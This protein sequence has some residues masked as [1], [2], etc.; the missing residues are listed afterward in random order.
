MNNPLVVTGYKDDLLEIILKETNNHKFSRPAQKELTRLTI[1]NR[2]GDL[3]VDVGEDIKYNVRDI[4]KNGYNN[5]LSQDKIAENITKKITTIKHKRA[6]AI[7]RTEIARTATASDYVINK[8]RGANAFTVDCRN[9][10]CDYCKQKVLKNP[11]REATG[12]GMTGDVEFGIDDVENLPPFHPNCRCVAMFFIKEED[13]PDGNVVVRDTET[14]TTTETTENPRISELEQLIKDEQALSDKWRKRGNTNLAKTFESNVKQYEEELKTL[15]NP[16]TAQTQQKPKDNSQDDI[17]NNL[18]ADVLKDVGLEDIAPEKKPINP[19]VKVEKNIK[20]THESNLWENLADKHGFELMEASDTRV[21][22][23]DPKFETPIQCNIPKNKEWIDY[24]NRGKKKINIEDA[25]T[26]YNSASE[27]QKKATP[28]IKLEGKSLDQGTV[29]IGKDVFQLELF[30]GAF[31]KM[32]GSINGGNFKGAMHHEMWHCVDIRM[33]DEFEARELKLL[34]SNKKGSSYK[35][36]VTKDR[37]SKKK[38]GGQNFCSAY[39]RQSGSGNK[40][41]EDFAEAGSVMSSDTFL[42]QDAI[43]GY[44]EITKK[45]FMEQY[46]NRANHIQDIIDNGELLW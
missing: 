32:E 10:A 35:K 1:E 13:I 43:G 46:P 23:Y 21:T 45:E 2:V 3:I 20:T 28:I 33:T 11:E 6:R 39:A 17:I 8:E 44:V 26:A 18:L 42:V 4:V 38:T 7:A 24:S 34:N 31:Y 37:R 29:T 40:L 16:T 30:E 12:K 15:K 5:K 41:Y 19:N 22:F 14:T 9:T 25:L 27:I 36:S